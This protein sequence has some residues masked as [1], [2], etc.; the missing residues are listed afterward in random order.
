MA[1]PS[2]KNQYSGGGKGGKLITVASHKGKVMR[3][4]RDS[5]AQNIRSLRT[6]LGMVSGSQRSGVQAQINNYRTAIRANRK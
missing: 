4:T 2:G 1:N 3:N 6:V 5:A